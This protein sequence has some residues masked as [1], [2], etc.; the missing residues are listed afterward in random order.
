M[1]YRVYLPCQRDLQMVR[2]RANFAEDFIL[3]N[4][5]MIKLLMGVLS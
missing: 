4:F 2:V 5:L 3:A 1:E